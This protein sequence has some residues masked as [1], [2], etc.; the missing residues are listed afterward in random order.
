MLETS[1]TNLVK[2]EGKKNMN[3]IRMFSFVRGS[4]TDVACLPSHIQDHYFV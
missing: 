1:D 2:W 4:I 3:V